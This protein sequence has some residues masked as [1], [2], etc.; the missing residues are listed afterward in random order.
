MTD[1]ANKVRELKASGAD[2]AEV[3]AAVGVLLALKEK[4][5][6]A[7]PPKSKKNKKKK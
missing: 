3:K 4:H 5:G 6:I 7:P 2:P 1:A